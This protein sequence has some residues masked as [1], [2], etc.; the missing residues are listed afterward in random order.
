[1]CSMMSISIRAESILSAVIKYN[2]CL[3]RINQ[4]VGKSSLNLKSPAKSIFLLFSS[5][6]FQ[7]LPVGSEPTTKHPII[8]A[9][10]LLTRLSTP[11]RAAVALWRVWRWHL[12]ALS[13]V[14]AVPSW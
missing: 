3:K 5:K 9:A 12:G 11:L 2:C 7:I 4:T 6:R 8:L 1:M 14:V 10:A 13:W